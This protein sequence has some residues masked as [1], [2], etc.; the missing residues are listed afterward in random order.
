MKNLFYTIC[1]AMFA[2]GIYIGIGGDSTLFNT[3]TAINPVSADF[4]P[5][6]LTIIGKF[7]K[8]CLHMS[9]IGVVSSTLL[10][11]MYRQTD[12]TKA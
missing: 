10:S 6:L 5:T 11:P 1:A 7:G 2:F 12:C 4:A 9:V 3:M 8:I